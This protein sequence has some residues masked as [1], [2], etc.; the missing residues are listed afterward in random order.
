MTKKCKFI[1][2]LTKQ[3]S[4]NGGFRLAILQGGT[5]EIKP[6]KTT[7]T[8]RYLESETSLRCLQGVLRG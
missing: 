8:I 3:E 6:V 5:R 4:K 1:K 2:Y 7:N